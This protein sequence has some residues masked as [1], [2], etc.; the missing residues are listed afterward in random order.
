MLI[1]AGWA[2][3]PD[4]YEFVLSHSDSRCTFARETKKPQTGDQDSYQ[5]YLFSSK[6]KGNFSIRIKSVLLFRKTKKHVFQKSHVV[7]DPL[8]MQQAS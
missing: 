5:M 6:M 3:L 1:E 2:C 4:H 7:F 8:A